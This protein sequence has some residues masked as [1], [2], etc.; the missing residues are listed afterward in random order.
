MGNFSGIN[1]T[2]KCVDCLFDGVF[3]VDAMHVIKI[4]LLDAQAFERGLAGTANVA[5]AIVDGALVLARFAHDA[6][7]RGDTNV[8]FI[9]G[10]EAAD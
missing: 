9:V 1:E 2:G 8:G 3:W 6:K 5:R 10:D 4:N 7:L